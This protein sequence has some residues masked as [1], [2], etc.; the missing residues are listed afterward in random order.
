LARRPLS[1]LFGVAIAIAIALI[2]AAPAGAAKDPRIVSPKD[3]RFFTGAPVTV[4]VRTAKSVGSLDAKL[5]GKT[6]KGAFKRIGAGSW[7]ASFAAGKL[8]RGK[9]NVAIWARPKGGRW[10]YTSVRF[11]LGRRARSLLKVTGPVGGTTT[12]SHV[13]LRREPVELTAKL[14]GRKLRWPIGLNPTRDETLRLAGD[15]GLHF[16]VNH[17]R[18]FAIGAGGVWDVVDRTVKVK[19]DRPLV[20]A[21]P[22]R[23]LAGPRRVRLDGSSS[24]PAHANAKLAYH[25]QIVGKPP[26]SKAKLKENGSVKPLLLTDKA[27][28]YQVRLQVTEGI[29]GAGSPLGKAA[30]IMTLITRKEMVPPIGEPIE[31]M[32][33]NGKSGS[34]ADSGIRV[35]ATTYWMGAPKGKTAQVLLL[36]R[37]TLEPL[38]VA[39]YANESEAAAFEGKV[40]EYGSNALTIISVPNL[41]GNSPPD[42]RLG[43]VAANIGVELDQITPTFEPGWSAIGVFGTKAGGTIGPGDNPNVKNGAEYA[44][45]LSGYLQ[46]ASG[47]GFVYTPASR[48]PFETDAIGGTAT[49]NKMV[50]DGNSYVSDPLA[51]SCGE[52]GFQIEVVLAET[53]APVEGA[54]FTTHGCGAPIE[55]TQQVQMKAYL[56][57][58]DTGGEHPGPKLVFIQSI[59][60]PYGPGLGSTYNSIAEG[61]EAVGGIGGAFA[62]GEHEG[63]LPLRS[64]YALV[65]SVGVSPPKRAEA[66]E[67]LTEYPAKITGVLKPSPANAY[68]P[69]IASP[70][71]VKA[72][73]TISEIAYQPAQEWPESSSPED[74]AALRYIAEQV[75]E[76]KQPDEKN[77]CYIPPEPD[78]R[79]MYCD[80]Q[81]IGHW[82]ENANILKAAKY[83]PGH[84][85]GEGEWKAVQHELAFEEFRTVEEIWTLLDNTEKI[86]SAANQIG[87]VDFE[88][89]TAETERALQPPPESDATGWWLELIGNLASTGSYFS[90]VINPEEQLTKFLGVIQGAMFEASSSL[91]ESNGEAVLRAFK[92]KSS[93]MARE[94]AAHYADDI[95]GIGKVGN[96]LVTDYGKLQAMRNSGLLGFKPSESKELIEAAAASTQMWSYEVLM[97]SAFEAVQLEAGGFFNP[98]VPEKATLWACNDITEPTVPQYPFGKAAAADEYKVNGSGALGVLVR[99]HSKLP[100]PGGLV[101]PEMPPAGLF[102]PIRE[103]SNGSKAYADPWFW[104]NT[105]DFPSSTNRK[106]RCL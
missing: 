16:G 29:A 61:I 40:K 78:V 91:F 90:N 104:H 27:G 55:A 2:A 33:A 4:K 42:V 18:V 84:G 41:H 20:G 86:F 32:V 43:V 23:Q 25:W 7:K 92:V 50:I 26:G 82:R 51:A 70:I 5:N 102:T 77:S 100:E 66:S 31:T 34:E 65:G 15:D 71:G 47:Q 38:Y 21:G 68:A 59:G 14:N 56:S 96:I 80:G 60:Q 22:D 76:L 98:K 19:R 94:L 8:A 74:K 99:A 72:N 89:L 24:A 54:T 103:P 105:F 39:S 35:G 49:T 3:G 37:T 73:S 6:V 46:W 44:G 79:S 67:Q 48:A 106:L 9:N 81:E 64:G 17:L 85:F 30:D 88:Q 93:E 87:H 28:R 58:I 11:T 13:H 75:L 57:G 36:D 95:G 52:G 101:Y 69:E 63:L 62:F 45:D 12:V 97:P 53:L 1:P 10:R 83:A